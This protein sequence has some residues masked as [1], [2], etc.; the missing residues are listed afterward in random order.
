MSLL[1]FLRQNTKK[2][3][4]FLYFKTWVSTGCLSTFLCY[5]AKLQQT[6]RTNIRKSRF[7]TMKETI[8]NKNNSLDQQCKDEVFNEYCR[9]KYPTSQVV[10]TFSWRSACLQIFY[11]S[12]FVVYIILC[13]TKC[14]QLSVIIWP[15]VSFTLSWK[16]FRMNSLSFSLI[17]HSM[18][19][20]DRVL[21]VKQNRTWSVVCSPPR[22]QV[23]PRLR[24]K[25]FRI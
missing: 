25:N 17:S 9:L 15:V 24:S 23:F 7:D 19:E 13:K 21:L 20:A 5:S 22:E 1:H 11:A 4:F 8:Q 12:N 10:K 16:T 14:C 2:K 6:L 3:S 18:C